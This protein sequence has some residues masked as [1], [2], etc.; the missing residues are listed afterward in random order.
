MPWPAWYRAAD[1]TEGTAYIPLAE[2]PAVLN[3]CG[4]KGQGWKYDDLWTTY[5]PSRKLT[6]KSLERLTREGPDDFWQI[7]AAA[8]SLGTNP[9]TSCA[10]LFLSCY[11]APMPRVSVRSRFYG[12]R[13]GGWQEAFRRGPIPGRIYHY[14]LNKAYR[15]AATVGLPDLRTA[16]PTRDFTEPCGIYLVRDVPTGA[17]P[18]RRLPRDAFHVVTSEERDALGLRPIDVVLVKGIAFRDSVSL[19]STFERIDRLPPS[20]VKRISHSFWGLWNT[21]SAPEQISWKHGERRRPLKNPWYNPIWSA[22]ITSRVKLRLNHWRKYAVHCFTDSLHVT[23]ELPTGTEPGEWKLVG[24]YDKLWIRA[25]GS[26]GD[27]E[28]VLK[29][30]GRG[31][32]LGIAQASHDAWHGVRKRW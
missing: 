32:D 8:K 27:G 20:L 2:F 16:R 26:W 22:F 15:W 25:P 13:F 3:R 18:W 19:A 5:C 24:I 29:H 9:P 30:A 11:R 1:A 6:F 17:I 10:E 31:A 12:W 4:R 7:M 23:E 14:D 21:T 28:Y